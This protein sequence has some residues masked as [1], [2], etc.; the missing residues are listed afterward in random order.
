MFRNMLVALAV[1]ISTGIPFAK[2]LSAQEPP[3]VEQVNSDP[4]KYVG[5]TLVFDYMQLQG[6]AMTQ[7]KA[8]V[9]RFVVKTP[10]GTT[11]GN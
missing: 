4:K 5:K 3:T 11:F 6:K 10:Q 8:K 2:T 9:F 1:V 7:P